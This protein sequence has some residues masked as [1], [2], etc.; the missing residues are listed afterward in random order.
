MPIDPSV[1]LQGRTP[2]VNS[3]LESFQ[4]NISIADMMASMQERQQ[5]AKEYEAE[6]PLRQ[7][8][9]LSQ[10]QK[11]AEEAAI[12]KAHT[13]S[14]K[15]FNPEVGDLEED[16]EKAYQVLDSV[17]IPGIGKG[18]YLRDRY[19][20][21]RSALAAATRAQLLDEAI[22]HDK[23]IDF[24]ATPA[25]NFIALK[26]EDQDAQWNEMRQKIVKFWPQPEVGKTLPYKLTDANRA[27]AMSTLQR[28]VGSQ[29]SART[30]AEKLEAS[31]AAAKLKKAELELSKT[32]KE[33]KA[34][35]QPKKIDESTNASGQRVLTMQRPDGTIFYEKSGD[36]VQEKETEKERETKLVEEAYGQLKLKGKSR[37][38]MTAAEKVAARRWDEAISEAS[39]TSADPSK[40]TDMQRMMALWRSGT[41]EDKALFNALKGNFDEGP[42]FSNRISILNTLIGSATSPVGK[43]V[44]EE[45]EKNRKLYL[46]I[47]PDLPS[48]AD[49]QKIVAAPKEPVATGGPKP[50]APKSK[51]GTVIDPAG[52]EHEVS[53]V[54]AAIK[55]IPGTR[56]K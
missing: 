38:K 39:K 6:A 3:P 31:E 29:D 45:Y 36:K 14:I 24:V 54:D 32:E 52:V 15:P 40:Q 26:P 55:M 42:T 37:D 17:D 8:V 41:P 50:A 44:P 19:K 28:I 25:R 51:A 10:M 43:L 46:P 16:E 27:G 30:M 18:S 5:R 56:R 9:N 23:Q 7:A 33:V 49:A 21:E 2:Q 1:A 47:W 12:K 53:D 13:E 11:L 35:D 22:G 20:T 48:Y 4:R 34:L